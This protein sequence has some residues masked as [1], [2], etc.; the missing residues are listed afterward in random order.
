ME[1][2]RPEWPP[3]LSLYA[4][5]LLYEPPWLHHE[6]LLPDDSAE[7]SGPQFLRLGPGQHD[8]GRAVRALGVAADLLDHR[9]GR[10]ASGNPYANSVGG[11]LLRAVPVRVGA[12][13]QD[14]LITLA[15]LP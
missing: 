13:E 11:E 9:Q 6:H 10:H 4:E 1:D 15:V 12:N 8:Q 5:V 14:P 3:A 7:H 2:D